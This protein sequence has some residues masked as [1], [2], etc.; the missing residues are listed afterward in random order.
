M[1]SHKLTSVMAF[2]T[3]VVAGACVGDDP[4]GVTGPVLPDAAADTGAA[5][6]ADAPDA[7]DGGR[8][9]AEADADAGPPCDTRKPWSSPQLLANVNSPADD[10]IGRLSPDELTIYFGSNRF[11][12]D[13]GPGRGMFDI[14]VAER[15]SRGAAFGTPELVASPVNGPA[16]DIH[17]MISEDR[18]NLLFSSDRS[19]AFA[20][21]NVWIASRLAPLDA[22]G[23][24]ALVANVNSSDADDSPFLSTKANEL[25]FASSRPG[26][27]GYDLYRATGNVATGFSGINRVTALNTSGNDRFPVLSAD[28][29][30]IF[31]GSNRMDGG[32][33]GSG[34]IWTAT[35]T[36][37]QA[38]F[39]GLKNVTE[40]NS[41]AFEYP[42]W[43]SPDGCRL[44]M[45]RIDGADD[46]IYM[47][48]RPK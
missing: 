10:G 18:L 38:A 11:A 31:W 25:W 4:S 27:G 40:L 5:I 8:E 15:S 34:D 19:A 36:S 13:A 28:G 32:A 20:G 1:V 48:E 41:L 46:N 9:D 42:S 43:L 24:P 29:L 17:P 45:G 2:L 35:R 23:S 14:M 21:T 33:L 39:T 26:T 44:Y 12:S 6:D 47:A 3:I 37:L 22:F 30:T 7:A 16:G